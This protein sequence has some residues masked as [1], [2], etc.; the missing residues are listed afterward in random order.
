MATSSKGADPLRLTATPPHPAAPTASN[1]PG[2]ALSS[3]AL[4]FDRTTF[5]EQ[6]DPASPAATLD[7]ATWNL[8]RSESDTPLP[9]AGAEPSREEESEDQAGAFRGPSRASQLGHYIR[10]RLT[11]ENFYKLQAVIND[12]SLAM[13]LAQQELVAKIGRY[14]NT[15]DKSGV[16]RSMLELVEKV[17]VTSP[18]DSAV[19]I[20]RPDPGTPMAS[21]LLQQLTA[22]QGGKQSVEMT[23]GG[24]ILGKLAPI[25]ADNGTFTGKDGMDRALGRLTQRFA[26]QAQGQVDIVMAQRGAP[27]MAP[28]PGAKP[29]VGAWS[30]APEAASNPA[31]IG[32]WVV[33][34]EGA[35]S[36][37]PAVG[38]WTSPQSATPA[39]DPAA[40][41]GKWKVGGTPSDPA[42]AP[43]GQWVQPDA[44]GNAQLAS[45]GDQGVGQWK[46][47][48]TSSDPANPP[49]GQWV[50]PDAAGNARLSSGGDRDVGQWKVPGTQSDPG[51]AP[52][53]QWVQPDAAGN[54]KLAAGGDQSVGQWQMPGSPQQ[55]GAPIGQ[56]TNPNAPDAAARMGAG[57]PAAARVGSW[58]PPG[59]PGSSLPPQVGQWLQAKDLPLADG[60]NLSDILRQNPNISG[61]RLVELIPGQTAQQPSRL[62]TIATAARSI[63]AK[64]FGL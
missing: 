52:V 23:Q 56:W 39:N 60:V 38:Q 9:G 1:G 42:S 33:P 49:V 41:L 62:G 10:D 21:N 50:Q 5:H 45:G 27:A 35:A 61:V 16:R 18:A 64:R 6:L 36:A 17:D 22:L 44:A 24:R 20:L 19:L 32:Q 48:G 3:S 63:L 2:F 12:P 43:I 30:V 47:P 4:G 46:V 34:G 58:I 28:P 8:D 25:L 26:Q 15:G 7:W 29:S 51:N 13:T 55:S 31:Q 40:E 53:G 59:A 37:Q 57:Q 14:A 54:A 11:V